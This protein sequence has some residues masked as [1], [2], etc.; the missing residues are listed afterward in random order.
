MAYTAT[1]TK[2]SVTQSGGLYNVSLSIVINDGAIDVLNF[3]ASVKYNNNAPD[4]GAIS[5]SLQDQIKDKWDTYV[6]NKEIFDAVALTTLVTSLQSQ[7][8]AYIN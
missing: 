1:I 4:M 2:S 3:I 7:T 6:A 5:N 8:N